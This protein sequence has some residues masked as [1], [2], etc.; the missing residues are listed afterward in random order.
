MSYLRMSRANKL[1]GPFLRASPSVSMVIS[2]LQPHAL[3]MK[4]FATRLL[5]PALL[6]CVLA[7]QAGD[8]SAEQGALEAAFERQMSGCRMV[9]HFTETGSDKAPQRDSYTI[10]KVKKLRDEKW[11]FN[12]SIEYNGNSVTLPL[13]VDVFWAGETPTIQVTD[14]M[15]PTL[16]KFNARIIVHGDQ[17]AGLWSGK[18]HGGH[19]YGVIEPG[20]HQQ[21]AA[22]QNPADNNWATWRGPDGSGTAPGNPPTE[23]SE[24]K[25]IKWKTQLPGLG[26][27][28][29]IVWG[30][31]YNDPT[32]SLD[33][34]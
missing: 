18:D 20:N 15:I 11:Q 10:V 25:N 30:D 26:N 13:G 8:D 16:G 7:A 34:T 19:M 17:Y 4:N 22:T 27:S 3:M 24:D 33:W 31:R 1:R 14:L 23:W 29:P 6:P 12:A 5:L 9:G 21:T 28:T 32:Q 2:A